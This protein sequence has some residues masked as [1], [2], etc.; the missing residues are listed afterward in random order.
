[1]FSPISSLVSGRV[2]IMINPVIIADYDPHWPAVYEVEK[3]LIVGVIGDKLVKV[4]HVGSTAVPDLGAKPIIDIMV[5]INR[6]SDA[7]ECIEPL[8]G[9]GYEYDPRYEVELPERRYFQKGQ[10]SNHYHLHMVE[11]TSDFWERHLLFRDF[12]RTH[13]ETGLQYQK[14]KQELAARYRTER[15]T[16]TESKT[17]FIESVVAR[18]RIE[19]KIS[20]RG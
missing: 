13:P 6:L 17:S 12:L 16:Y 1:M 18:A 5:G 10:S 11:V 7:K 8:K 19:N 15:E 20:S 14:L 2:R 9:I 3:E 4:E